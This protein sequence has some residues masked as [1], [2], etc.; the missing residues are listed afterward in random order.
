MKATERFGRID[1]SRVPFRVGDAPSIPVERYTSTEFFQLERE[2]LWPK[3][4]QVACRMEE[5]PSVGDFAEYEIADQSILVVR[6]SPDTIQAYFNT[7]RHRGS[8]LAKTCGHFAGGEIT[9]PFHGWRWKLD[10]SNSFIYGEPGFGRRIDRDKVRLHEC[11]VATRWG[12]VF[13]NM[14]P[15]AP[16]LE[17]SLDGIAP[18]L[19]PVR[20]DLMRV[21]WWQYIE[22]E[23]NWKVAQEAFLE[24]YH[25]MQAHPELAMGRHGDDF[26]M[27]GFESFGLHP[28]GH[29][30]ARTL[31]FVAPARGASAA[32]WLSENDR[33]LH[34][35]ARTWISERQLRIER[36]LLAKGLSDEEFFSEFVSALQRDAAE[37]GIP[38][39]PPT[40][41]TTGWCH[42]FPNTTLICAYGH[43]L[44]YKFRP[45][46]L[47]PQR[48][49][50]DATAVSL[51]PLGSPEQARPERVGPVPASEWPF[52]LRQDIGNIERQQ[53]GM[54]NRGFERCHLSPSYEPMILN[55]HRALDRYLARDGSRSTGS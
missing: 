27:A 35:G 26:D 21:D 8:Q 13:I 29:G 22:L 49:I 2:L 10:G 5:V 37:H 18:A 54:R 51:R 25:I 44:I 39:P 42:I 1:T 19:D 47:D 24:A 17:E 30:W 53:A 15:Q 32:E 52:V 4:W 6:S 12:L 50:F 11:K 43:A 41:E 7:C 36:D 9:C 31:G 55:M 14:D 28:L 34:E 20:L 45:D 23:A 46:G 48:S 33:V 38:L 40:A 3:V 16:P